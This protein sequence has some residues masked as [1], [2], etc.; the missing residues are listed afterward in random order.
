MTEREGTAGWLWTGSPS[1]FLRPVSRLSGEGAEAMGY[2]FETEH[3]RVRP[4]TSEDGPRLYEIHLDEAVKKWFPNESYENPEEAREAAA[5]F[6]LRA[7]RGQLPFVLAVERKDTG[8]LIGDAGVS[9]A[10]GKPGE[11]EIGY[12]I[13]RSCRGKGYAA[14]IVRA[15]T[16]FAASVFQAHAVVGRVVKGNSASVRVLEKSGYRFVREESGAEDDPY[17]NGMLVYRKE[18]PAWP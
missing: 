10:E 13:C 12:V 15:M 1:F 18:D 16:G 3:L 6:G 17:G 7:E 9:E 14:E 2:V 11:V 8:E 4:F 5:F